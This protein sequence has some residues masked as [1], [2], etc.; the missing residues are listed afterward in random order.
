MI[1][2]HACMPA[3]F[4]TAIEKINNVEDES[5][6]VQC[7]QQIDGYVFKTL[8]ICITQTEISSTLQL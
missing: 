8:P 4:V 7:Q 6:W 2:H 1:D 5:E 3:I